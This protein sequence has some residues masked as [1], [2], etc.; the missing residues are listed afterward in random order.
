MSVREVS[1]RPHPL[2]TE[3]PTFFAANWHLPTDNFS[4]F[5][6]P[7]AAGDLLFLSLVIPTGAAVSAAERR[8]PHFV[9]IANRCI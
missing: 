7:R 5:V 8:D 2:S 4:W 9:A 1:P 6:I 3:G